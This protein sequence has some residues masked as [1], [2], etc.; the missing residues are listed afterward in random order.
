MEKKMNNSSSS[1]KRDPSF[2]MSRQ[3]PEKRIVR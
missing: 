1:P 3:V 2:V